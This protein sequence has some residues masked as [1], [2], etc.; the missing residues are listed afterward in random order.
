MDVFVSDTKGFLTQD[1]IYF[2]LRIKHR[3]RLFQ[4]PPPSSPYWL[5]S[6][7]LICTQRSDW[8]I[9]QSFLTQPLRSPSVGFDREQRTS[10]FSEIWLAL[11]HV[12]KLKKPQRTIWLDIP[13]VR[14][15]NTTRSVRIELALT[16]K[17]RLP[18]RVLYLFLC[19]QRWEKKIITAT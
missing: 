12:S 2:L 9:D 16:E 4:N 11:V 7:S 13:S 10:G 8:L 5:F 1:C 3:Q 17:R 6:N 14:Q 15:L 19:V 18:N